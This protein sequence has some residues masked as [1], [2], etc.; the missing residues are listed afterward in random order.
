LLNFVVSATRCNIYKQQDEEEKNV[1]PI[2]H[3]TKQKWEDG[4]I[5]VYRQP[6]TNSASA[7]DCD[8]QKIRVQNPK[9]KTSVM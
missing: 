6:K 7:G 3:G 1:L 9:S 8:R 2:I 4:S 5:K